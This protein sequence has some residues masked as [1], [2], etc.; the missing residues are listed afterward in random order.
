MERKHSYELHSY[1]LLADYYGNITLEIVG[2]NGRDEI[3]V[4]LYGSQGSNLYAD[5]IEGR[6]GAYE[7]ANKILSKR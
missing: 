7:R 3:H 6:D 2:C 5:L 1:D 4:L